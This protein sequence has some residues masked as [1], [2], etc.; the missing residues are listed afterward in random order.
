MLSCSGAAQK[1]LGESFCT[2]VSHQKMMTPAASGGSRAAAR[3]ELFDALADSRRR[4]VLRLVQQRSPDG[5]EKA[6]LA[7]YLAAVSVDERPAEVSDDDHQ[8]ALVDFHHRLMPALADI[9]LLEESDD[10]TLMLGTHPALDE[11]RLKAVVSTRHDADDTTLDAV[12]RAVADER[13]RT[14]MSILAAENRPLEIDPLARRLAARE[15]ETT[16]REV[17]RDRVDEVVE[18]A[19]DRF[20][21][22]VHAQ[23]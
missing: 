7:R 15:A 3:D 14:I 1:D 19:I 22:A 16:D 21:E 5:I 13:R 6:A 4:A 18:Y 10:G 2:L 17:A 23:A 12:F 9:G 11:S 8:Q 20:E